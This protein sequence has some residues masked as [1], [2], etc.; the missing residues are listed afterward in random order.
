MKKKSKK[1]IIR[2]K[3]EFRYHRIQSLNK[4]GKA[5]G[6]RHPS[7]VF[8]EKGNIYIYVTITHSD[9]IDDIVL[10]ELRKNPNPKDKRKSY[11]VAEIREDTKDTFGK[12]EKGWEMDIL[13]DL[14]IRELYKKR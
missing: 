11:W 7:Y 10:I 6:L 3:K 9:K 4:N 5:I 1:S 12:R 2:K 14:E 13:D 8:L